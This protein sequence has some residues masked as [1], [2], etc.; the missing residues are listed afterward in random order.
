MNTNEKLH[1][2]FRQHIVQEDIS[3][4]ENILQSSDYFSLEEIQ[5]ARSLAEEKLALGEASSYQFLFAEVENRI[6]AFVCYG[7]V[8]LTVSSFDL[9]WMA[10]L[11]EKCQGGLGTALL[12]ETETRILALGGTRL[13]IDTSSRSQYIPTRHFYEHRGYQRGAFLPEYYGPE[14]GKV[15]YYKRL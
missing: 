2:N 6:S 15:I 12:R 5:V 1:V 9:Y 8:P 10:V 13:Y 4:I 7:H 14:D 3:E 11:Q